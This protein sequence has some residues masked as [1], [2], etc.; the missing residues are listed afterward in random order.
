[1]IRPWM[2]LLYEGGA[3]TRSCTEPPW[4]EYISD[5][6]EV[7]VHGTKADHTWYLLKGVCSTPP[8]PHGGY[9]RALCTRD[10][11]RCG[12]GRLK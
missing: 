9:L 8:H 5:A 10:I 6:P 2:V 4:T 1:M 3:L 11:F 12:L 7:T